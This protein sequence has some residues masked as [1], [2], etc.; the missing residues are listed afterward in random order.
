MNIKSLTKKNQKSPC[1]T[2]KLCWVSE[3]TSSGY[4]DPDLIYVLAA[5]LA[6]Y[7]LRWS[8]KVVWLPEKK[9]IVKNY[10]IIMRQL[11]PI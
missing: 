8:I 1:L 9:L 4:S 5:A 11:K 2:T 10:L 7:A 3:Q 6:L